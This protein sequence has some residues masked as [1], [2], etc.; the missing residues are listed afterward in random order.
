MRFS[1]VA[2]GV[3]LAI[4]VAEAG[5]NS[6]NVGKHHRR[7]ENFEKLRSR[8]QPSSN[9]EKRASTLNPQYL[10]NTTASESI[11]N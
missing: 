9:F 8:A 6:H 3:A 2:A 4:G 10:T 5:K 11:P 7:E 1:S